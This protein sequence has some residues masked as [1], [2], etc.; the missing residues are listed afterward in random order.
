[1][2]T[3]VTS[4]EDSRGIKLIC[5]ETHLTVLSETRCGANK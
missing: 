3:K 1:M 5:F 4:E 2:L